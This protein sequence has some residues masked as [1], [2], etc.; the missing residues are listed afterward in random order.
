MEIDATLGSS[1]LP[2]SKA[3]DEAV[4]SSPARAAH[5]EG[6]LSSVAVVFPAYNEEGNIEKTVNLALD[7]FSKY[8]DQV[9]IIPVND[10]GRDRTGEIIDRMA[11]KDL[12]VAPVHHPVN[13]GYGGALRSGF[14]AADADYVFFSDSDGQFDMEEIVNLLPHILNHDMVVGYRHNRADPFHRKLNAWAWGCMVK[15]LFG[16]KA[17][18]IDCAFKLFRRKVFDNVQLSSSGAMINTELLAQA[19]KQGFSLINIP[20]SHYPREEGT[21]T[22]ANPAVILKAFAELFK[23]YRRIS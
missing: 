2:E 22:G 10:G 9:T 18:D 6:K 4:T 20:V 19:R 12:R 5:F 1:V 21:P 13:R 8:F 17:K 23:L 16:I 11:A 15:L 14:E 7:A 3:R